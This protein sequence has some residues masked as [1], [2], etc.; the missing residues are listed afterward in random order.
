MS[1]INSESEQKRV[2]HWKEMSYASFDEIDRDL[3]FH[4]S[5]VKEPEQLT[6]D[7]VSQYNTKGYITGI[8]IFPDEKA[9]AN[10]QYFDSLL[11]RILSEGKDSY[12]IST[13]HRKYRKVFDI[14]TDPL[15][16]DYVSDILGEHFVLWGC[17]F[18][19]K[20]PQDGKSVSWHQDA[21]YWPMTPSKTV[22]VW[23]AIDD[24]DCD[25]ACMRVIP[26]SHLCGHLTWR[27]SMDM[28]NNVLDQTVEN[29]ESYGDPPVDLILKAGE[30][31]LHSDLILHG[32]EPNRSNRRRC[33][34]TMRYAAVDV[35]AYMGWH[36]K[37]IVCR[38]ID[39]EGHWADEPPPE[40]E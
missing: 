4:P 38:G 23:L 1:R 17:H 39:P 20:M 33:G 10:R 26:A 9:R 16:I 35:R 12:S 30:V 25:N 37:G 3:H 11:T 19:C 5:Q 14:A 13:A 8:R 6:L 15:I 21:S 24:S 28:E 22:T 18:F 36:E 31:S 32:S 2:T 29:A 27:K 40:A 7:Q 34:L